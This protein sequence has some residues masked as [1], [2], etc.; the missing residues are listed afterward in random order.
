MDE[1]LKKYD[2]YYTIGQPLVSDAEYDK[3]RE[4]FYKKS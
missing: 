2:Y 4:E 3:L 1:L